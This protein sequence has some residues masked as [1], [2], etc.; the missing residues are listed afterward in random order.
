MLTI[1]FVLGAFD[2]TLR[3][4][5]YF[6]DPGPSL[7]FFS[8]WHKL[9]SSCVSTGSM[10]ARLTVFARKAISVEI[11]IL[12]SRPRRIGQS[13]SSSGGPLPLGLRHP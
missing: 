3:H 6:Q 11:G 7:N 4:V 9:F 2:F 5:V 10:G 13:G 12:G 1:G 8:I